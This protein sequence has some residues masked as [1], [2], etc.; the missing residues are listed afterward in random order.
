[1]HLKDIDDMGAKAYEALGQIAEKRYDAE[2]RH[3]NA[4]SVIQT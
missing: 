3:C 1:M 2:L 4:Y